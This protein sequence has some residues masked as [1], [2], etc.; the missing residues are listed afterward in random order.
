MTIFYSAV[1]VKDGK[2]NLAQ[3]KIP[4]YISVQG[5]RTAKFSSEEQI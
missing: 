5:V 4:S 2:K 3:K 1:G